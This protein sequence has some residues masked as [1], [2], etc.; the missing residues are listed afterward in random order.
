MD[1]IIR[2]T[3]ER[4]QL[5]RIIPMS[6]YDAAVDTLNAYG[7]LTDGQF[8][9]AP[10]GSLVCGQDVFERWEKVMADFSVLDDRLAALVARLG[11]AEADDR[12]VRA[13][14]GQSNYNSPEE[15]IA[16]INS[17]LDRVLKYDDRTKPKGPKP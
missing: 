11:H 6:D 9:D 3:S 5:S 10:D 12:F 8:E 13:M 16:A 2:E 4:R 17:A 1:I 14:P 15:Q 7:A